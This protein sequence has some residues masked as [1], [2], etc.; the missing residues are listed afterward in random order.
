[1]CPLRQFRKIPEEVIKK[2]EKKSFAFDRMFD[3]GPSEL[4]ELIRMPK[5]G[6][7]LHKYVHQVKIKALKYISKC[8]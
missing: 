7:P 8:A 1:M 5:M 2:I 3:L 6:K 4:G